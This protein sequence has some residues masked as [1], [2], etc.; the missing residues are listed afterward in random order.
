[1]VPSALVVLEALPLTANGKLDRRALPAPDLTPQQVRPPRTPQEEVLCSL[2]AEVL[3]VERVGIDD[4]FFALGGDSIMSIQLVSRA[5]QAGLEITPRAVFQHQTV[6]ALAASASVAAASEE[7]ED[8]AVGGVELLPI[9]RWFM[10]RGG[11]IEQFH[12]AMVLRLPAGLREADLVGAL[13]AVLDHHDALRLRLEVLAGGEWGLEIAA[14]GSVRAAECFRRIDVSGLDGEGLRSCIGAAAGTAAEGLSPLQGRLVQAIWFDAGEGA[15]GRLLL[16]IHH[17]A[18][19]GVSWRILVPD[20]AAAWSALSRGGMPALPRRGTSYRGWSRRLFAEAHTAGRLGELEHWRGMLSAPSLRLVGGS[21]QADRDLAGTARHL[22]LELPAA[23]TGALL[24][25]VASAFH[26]GINDVLLSGLAVAVADWGRRH[27]RSGGPAVLVDLEGHGREEIF[28]DVDLSRTV[29]WFT[30][31]YPVRLDPGAIDL[32]EALGGGAALGRAVKSIKE[33]LRALK[34][35]GLGY[36]LLRYLNAETGEQLSGHAGAQLGFNYLGR[37]TGGGG[38][39]WGLAAEADGLGG[40]GDATMPLAHALEVNA[41]TL[42]GAEGPRLR[43]NWTWAPALLDEAAV[44]DLA[45]SWFAALEALVGHAAQPGAGGRTPSDV[46]LAGLTQ[47]ELERLEEA[48]PSLEDILPLS[49]LQEGLLFHALY[50]AAG[51]DLYTMQ[52]AFAVEGPLE[53]EVLRAAAAVL[54]QRHASL[55]A[56]FRHEQLSRPVQVVLS[57]V[58][59]PFRSVDLSMLKEA[60]REERWARLLQDDR[61][62]RF[63]VTA[64]P[65]L[66]FTL[67]RLGADRH[68]LLFAA[69]HILLDGWSV[70][71]LVQELLTLYAQRGSA[72]ALPRVTPYREY[73][74]WLGAQDRAAAIAAWSAALSGLDEP[75]LI[76]PRER[77]RAAALPEQLLLTL[78]AGLTAA[79]TQQARA[80]GLTLNTC[81]QGAWALLLGRLMG[82]DDVVF[83]ITVAGRPPEIAGIES[84]VGLFINTLPLRV[85]LAPGQPL[86]EL[87]AELQDSQSRLMAYQHVGLAEIQGLT[88]LG[89]LFDTLVVFENYPVDEIDHLG[90]SAAADGLRFTAIA[91]HDASH[92]PLSLAA[93]PG[94][95]LRLRLE[96]ATDLFDRGSVEGIGSRL[97]RLLEA[98]VAEPDRAIGRLDILSAAERQ[99]IVSDW[100]ATARPLGFANIPELFAAQA[101]RTPEA[102][103]VVYG[104]QQLSYG[105]L[106]A[107]A[108]QLAHHLRGLGVGPEVVVGLCVERS[109]EMLVGVLGILKAGGAYLPLDPAY[110]EE[111]LAFMLEDARAP[112]LLTQ[113][114]L[115]DQLPAYGARIVQLDA[116]WPTIA[117]R[118]ATASPVALH[119]HNTAYVIYTSGSTGTP[120]GV[121][122]SHHNVVRLVRETN[123]VELTA[124]DVFLQIAPLAFDASTFEIWGALLNG[125]RACC[126]SG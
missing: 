26:G 107:R 122:V 78:D 2:Y 90:D 5:R 94:E 91:G 22:A 119:P 39:D 12:Q 96:Y 112:V 88:G 87:L 65:L 18:V 113:A 13:Q 27:G 7:A 82:R 79:L 108:N 63:D 31:L 54:V 62:E 38:S 33:Q 4:N 72:A 121:A 3:G 59:V 64:P 53:S 1:M 52:I 68:R 73:L 70:P 51:V 23:V 76:A 14:A 67:V 118:P 115:L 100:N 69:H 86:G 105:E 74:A 35:N 15:A 95:Q 49:P 25:R 117:R 10:E 28:A 8:D 83:G 37:F 21:L 56:A 55:R 114:K 110:P 66:R 111:R 58:E 124:D 97:I 30:T 40:G 19:D 126:L 17:L 34:D 92:Y 6:E 48:Y 123:Y 98:V 20:V 102:T 42:D 11:P 60:E 71:V 116:D 75:T 57:P 80:R 120:K 24:T 44:K 46:P 9:M 45:R 84:M 16:S 89:E 32:G 125:A 101:A 103:A 81:I 85:K 104:D 99:T 50:D 29:G 93:I 109:L 61:A 106:D 77:G 47:G 43:A 41:L 36:G